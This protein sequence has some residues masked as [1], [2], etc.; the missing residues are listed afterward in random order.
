MYYRFLSHSEDQQE[1]EL[2]EIE[3]DVPTSSKFVKLK[4]KILGWKH[5]G[6]TL[7]IFSLFLCIGLIFFSTRKYSM[8][9]VPPLKSL[10]KEKT[11]LP[12]PTNKSEA[13]DYINGQ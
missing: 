13:E 2:L 4:S 5:Y 1:E 9:N 6:F 8:M 10:R 7:G 11:V 3:P 12:K